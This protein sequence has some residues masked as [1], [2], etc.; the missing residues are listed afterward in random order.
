MWS[1]S[2]WKPM[3]D[4]QK[5]PS[6]TKTVRMIHMEWNRK[7][8]EAITLGTWVLRRGHKRVRRSCRFRDPPW[9]ASSSNHFIAHSP[10]GSNAGRMHLLR[11]FEN[12]WNWQWGCKKPRVHSWRA[13]TLW[14]EWSGLEVSCDYPAPAPAKHPFWPPCAPWHCSTLG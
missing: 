4:W 8:R 14:A 13:H 6:T 5:D 11:W 3:G 10:L 1:K 12:Q 9:G 7:V 2:Y